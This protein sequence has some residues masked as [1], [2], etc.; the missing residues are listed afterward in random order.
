MKEEIASIEKNQ[1]WN[2]V[3]TPQDKR[4]IALRWIDKVKVNP[5]GE[6]VRHKA[7]FVAKGYLQWAGID[8]GEVFAPVA[9]LETIRVVV[10]FATHSDW[11]MHQ[12]NVKSAFLN[13]PLEEDVYVMQ[14]Q[15]FEVRGQEHKVFKLK[16]ALYGLKQAPRAWNQRIDSFLKQIGFQRCISECGVYIKCWNDKVKNDKLI[17]YL[18]VDDLLVTESNE[19]HITQFK[20]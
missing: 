2:L 1:S 11:S 14:P 3:E 16:K 19:E 4:P 6:V 15:G 7:R 13:G 20:N 17:I 8:Y 18:Y 5:K 12:L 10:S 9:R